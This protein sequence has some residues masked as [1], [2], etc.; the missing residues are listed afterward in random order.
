MLS[1]EVRADSFTCPLND[2]AEMFFEPPE[3]GNLCSVDI[4]TGAEVQFRK[5]CGK[6]LGHAREPYDRCWAICN[7]TTPV[8]EDEGDE[9]LKRLSRCVKAE[10]ANVNRSGLDIGMQCWTGAGVGRAEK[11]HSGVAASGHSS[12]RLIGILLLPMIAAQLL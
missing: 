8:D 6:P 2:F 11:K 12:V 1:V 7:Y 10:L 3:D 4:T 5:C 9:D